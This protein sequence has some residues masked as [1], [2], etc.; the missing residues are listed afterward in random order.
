MK[1]LK[2]L[3]DT[4]LNLDIDGLEFKRESLKKKLSIPRSSKRPQPTKYLEDSL[5]AVNE[6]L[7]PLYEEW[8]RR[9]D[10][11]GVLFSKTTWNKIKTP[12]YVSLFFIGLFVFGMKVG[13]TPK[14]FLF[15][16]F[17]TFGIFG[18]LGFL[19]NFFTKRSGLLFGIIIAW[20]VIYLL[21][22]LL[23]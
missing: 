10:D 2:K 18:L 7:L 6:E 11:R 1:D 20:G 17:I 15:N 9:E 16:S 4:L 23:L 5:E 14:E 22:Y 13:L 21:V 12:V 19:F 3:S 8:Q